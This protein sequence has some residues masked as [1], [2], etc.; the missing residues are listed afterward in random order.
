MTPRPVEVSLRQL[1]DQYY[2][3]SSDLPKAFLLAVSGGLDSMALLYAFI[4]MRKRLPLKIAVAH[5]HHGGGSPET[6]HF[7]NQA[8]DVVR[9]V[10]AANQVPFYTN[11]T[12]TDDL[13]HVPDYGASEA[14]L[15]RLRREALLEIKKRAQMPFVVF[16]H[17]RDDL[18]ETRLM[19]LIRGTGSLGIVAMQIRRGAVLRP[20][21]KLSRLDLE[22]YMRTV[23]GHWVE[24]P[25]NAQTD[26]LR[27][28][29]RGSWLPALEA[30]QPGSKAVLAQSLNLLA[31]AVSKSDS[32]E[33]CFDVDGKIIRSELLSL[34]LEEKKRVFAL[35]LRRQNVKDYGLSH[36]NEL[37]KRLDVERK[38]LTFTLAQK[39]WLANARHIW[40]ES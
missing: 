9:D 35:Y 38:E 21:L 22:D 10:C 34:S 19:R 16:A 7:R 31:Q 26:Y 12:S 13:S 33:H 37:V 14:G 29:I 3:K 30:R 15:R 32:L 5:V 24:D 23:S 36:I 28:W 4:E 25:S 17:H 2:G 18:L 1:L 39:N 11:I 8:H 6:V 27:N 20:F 40:C